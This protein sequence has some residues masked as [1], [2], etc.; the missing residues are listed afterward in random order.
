MNV[1]ITKKTKE[2]IYA[3]ELEAAKIVVN[4]M[5]ED[6]CSAIWYAELAAA[7]LLDETPEKVFCASAEVMPNCRAWNAFGNAEEE[8]G[9]L[10]VWVDFAAKSWG[11]FIE[12]GFYLTDIW[13]LSSENRDEIKRHM[14]ARRYKL[15]RN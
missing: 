8:T 15:S 13:A 11:E 5:K 9:R 12:G 2:A 4:S 10:D 3:A 14:Y 1:K 6:E 7:L